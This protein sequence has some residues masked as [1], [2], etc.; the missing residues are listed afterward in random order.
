MREEGIKLTHYG[1]RIDSGDLAYLSKSLQDAG[2]CRFDDATISASS[3]LDEYLIDSLK[4]QDAK[5]QFLGC[6]N[7]PHHGKDNPAFGGVYKLVQ[8]KMQTV[9]TLHQRSNC[10]KTPKKSQIRAIKQFTV[11]T[12]SLPVRLRLT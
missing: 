1:I 11:F 6:W 5:I 4:T 10:P 3:D 8:S 12:A 7:Q 9:Q 2:C